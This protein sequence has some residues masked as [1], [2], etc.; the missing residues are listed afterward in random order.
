[1]DV[2]MPIMDGLE[3]LNRIMNECPTAV[4]MLSSTTKKGTENTFAAMNSGAFDF[5]ANLREPFHWTYI[6]SRKNSM[7]KL[8]LPAGQ[9]FT[10]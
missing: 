1:L 9:M 6:K 7:K 5:V 8:W 4:V 3:A 2:E 10:N